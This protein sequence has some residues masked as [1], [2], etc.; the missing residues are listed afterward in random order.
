MTNHC[1]FAKSHRV[2]KNAMYNWNFMNKSMI[3]VFYDKSQNTTVNKYPWY[4]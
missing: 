4:L 3:S 2:I 1:I